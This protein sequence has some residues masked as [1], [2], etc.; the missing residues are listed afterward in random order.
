MYGKILIYPE[1][2]APPAPDR[3]QFFEKILILS[4]RSMCMGPIRLCSFV[5]FFKTPARPWCLSASFL[6]VIS[7]LNYN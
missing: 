4:H 6:H 5:V 7:P 1:K 3:Q 2:I